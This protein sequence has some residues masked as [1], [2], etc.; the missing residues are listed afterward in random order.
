MTYLQGGPSGQIYGWVDFDSGDGGS[1][2][3]WAATVASQGV[4]AVAQ[5]GW[6]NIP[7]LSQSN[8]TI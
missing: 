2:G 7:N 1:P 4:L 3:M 6:W 5:A 8:P